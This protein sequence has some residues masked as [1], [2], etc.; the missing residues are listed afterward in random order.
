MSKLKTEK[1][2]LGTIPSELSPA[3]AGG[4]SPMLTPKHLPGALNEI[5][6]KKDLLPIGDIEDEITDEAIRKKTRQ[7]K[8]QNYVSKNPTEAA[9]LINTWLHENE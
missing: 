4:G 8:I 9:K 5:K 7:E 6:K 1:I 3:T 2:F